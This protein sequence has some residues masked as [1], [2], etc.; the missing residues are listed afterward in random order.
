MALIIKNLQQTVKLNISQLHLDIT[1]IRRLAGYQNFGFGVMLTSTE[2]IHQLNKNYRDEDCATDVLAFP[3]Y[4]EIDPEKAECFP[5]ITSKE[6]MIL[7][8]IVL[9]V[10]YIYSISQEKGEH[11]ESTIL[12]MTT[13]G[14]C[15]LLG[16][17]HMNRDQWTQMRNKEL[18]ILSRFNKIT[19]YKCSPL[20]GIGHFTEM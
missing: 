18:N 17:D 19:G 10:P 7:G 20:L 14:L 9:G 15:H 5:P 8:D 4:D 16:Y 13:H 3:Y 6:E 2:E 11:F 1:L 12:T